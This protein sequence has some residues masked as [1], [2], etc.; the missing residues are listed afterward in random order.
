M[1]SASG[2]SAGGLSSILVATDEARDDGCVVAAAWRGRLVARLEEGVRMSR[3]SVAGLVAIAAVGGLACSDEGSPLVD[4]TS[5]PPRIE[6]L[7]VSRPLV[8]PGPT[9]EVTR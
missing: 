5:P 8:G 9:V 1:G 2:F 4:L 7:A 6:E 3:R